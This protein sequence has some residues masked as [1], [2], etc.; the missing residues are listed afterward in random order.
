MRYL[1]LVIVAILYIFSLNTGFTA[2]KEKE[3]HNFHQVDHNLFRSGQPRK[4]GMK[5]AEARGIK[6]VI[7]LRQIKDD[8]S[9][10]KGTDLKQIR[11]PLKAKELTYDDIVVVLS[12]IEKAEKPVLIHCLRGSD[13]TGCMVAAYQMVNGMDK[14]KAI[15]E[16]MQPEYGYK[17]SWFP[18]ILKLLQSL[19]VEKLKS[20]IR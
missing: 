1:P 7:N 11:V 4:S 10:I 19:D 20:D 15:D 6:T 8:K 13:R 18:N 14:Q 2:K 17:E 16:F 9:A 3:I 12:A 5:F